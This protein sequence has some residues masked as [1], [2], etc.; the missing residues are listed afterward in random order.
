MTRPAVSSSLPSHRTEGSDKLPVGSSTLLSAGNK[1]NI[2][3]PV[4][5]K[6]TIFSHSATDVAAHVEKQLMVQSNI[7]KE[8]AQRLPHYGL[9]TTDE[10][11]GEELFIPPE[12]DVRVVGIADAPL[13]VTTMKR[14]FIHA[15]S[16]SLLSAPNFKDRKNETFK[17]LTEQGTTLARYDAEFLLKVALY[18]RCDLNIRTT[19][20][21]LL[22]LS[23][24][25]HSC[26]PHIRKYFGASI[27]LP[28]D[29]IEV[30]DI[31]QAFHDKSLNFGS[32]PS[33]LR[34]AMIERFPGFDVYQLAKYNK[35]SSKKKKKESPSA[36]WKGFKVGSP[37]RE[38]KRRRIL[39]RKD[40]S[41]SDAS[42]ESVVRDEESESEE[43]LQRLS[44][45]L[46]QLIRKLHM[47]KPVDH[48]M[49]ILGRKYPEDPEAFRRSGLPGMWDQDRAGKRMKLPTPEMWE[50]QVSLRGNKAEVW[51]D[52]IDHKKLPFMAMLRNLRNLILSNMS[53]KHHRLIINKLTDERS[54]VN[55]R[56][57]PFRFFSAYEVL[58]ELEKIAKDE[59]V[60]SSSRNTGK[61]GEQ[62]RKEAARRKLVEKIDVALIQRYKSALDTALKISTCYNVKPIPGSTLIFCSVGK[63]MK[64]RCTSARGLGK[65]RTV[66]EVGILLGLMCKFSCEHCRMWV[67]GES[68][69]VEVSLKEGTILDNMGVVLETVDSHS[70]DA[71]DGKL[72]KSVL[73][74]VLNSR[75][76]MDNL[77]VLNT[78]TDLGSIEGRFLSDFLK[79][80]RRVVNPNLL[81]VHVNLN[82]QSAGFSTSM[83][84]EH[85]NDIYLAGY[86]DQILRFIAERG[87][88]GQ[89]TYVQNIDK[90]YNLK[91]VKKIGL[92][93]IPGG[94]EIVPSLEKE[95]VFLA[96][97][98]TRIWRTVR[99]FISST[100]K[101]MHAERDLL[102]R[103]VFPEL[104]A[105]AHSRH[106]QLYEVD[107]RWGVTEE[108]ARSE[109]AVEICL[110]EVSRC[111]YFVGILGERYGWS[112]DKYQAPD[113]PEYEWLK[114]YP[115]GRSITE[116]EVYHAAL[117]QPEQAQNKAFFFF[118]DPSFL[119]EVPQEYLPSFASESHESHMKME[120]LKSRIRSSGLEV[121]DN[122]LARWL[123]VVEGKPMTGNLEDFGKRVLNVLWNRIQ[124]DFPEEDPESDPLVRADIA[125]SAF[126]Q[127][128]SE[129]FVGR[130]KLLTKAM[131]VVSHGPGG[132]VVGAGKPGSGKSAFMSAFLHHYSQLLSSTG[133]SDSNS[134]VVYHFIG[135][136]PDSSFL[137]NILFRICHKLKKH[138]SLSLSVPEDISE[139]LQ[140]WPVMLK[141][142]SEVLAEKAMLLILIDALDLLED[143]HGARTLEWIPSQ[144]PENVTIFVSCRE[145][146]S[147]YSALMHRR[148]APTVITIGALDVFDKAE[149]VRR[150]LGK[151]KKK[152]EETAFNNQMK[153]LLSKKEAVNP[154]YLH[155]ACEELRVFGIFE[156]VSSKIRQMSSTVAGLLQ[157]ILERLEEEHGLE[158]V[159][160]ALSLLVVARNG[161]QE[162]EL[163]TL[164]AIYGAVG[165]VQES[166]IQKLPPIMVARLFR[167]LLGYLQP[168][169]HENNDLLT[170]S[171]QDIEKAVRQR[172]MKG[173]NNDFERKLHTVASLYFK[174]KA[175]PKGDGSFKGKE[176]R[177]FSEL[178]YHLTMAGMWKELENLL[179]SLNFISAKAGFGLSH[180]LLEDYAPGV[181]SL[182]SM[183]AR[184]VKKVTQNPKVE[185]FHSFVSRNLHIISS[186][187]ALV[188]QQ[189]FNEPSQSSISQYAKSAVEGTS[190]PVVEWLNKPETEQ[191]CRLTIT[192]GLQNVMCVAVSS[193]EE[194]VSC[195]LSSGIAKVYE[196]ATGREVA[197]F[198][199]HAGPITGVTFVSDARLCTASKDS[200]LSL[201]DLKEG[202]RI[203]VMK[204]HTHPVTGCVANASGR[205]IVSVS[206]DGAVRVWNGNDGSQGGVL[207][208][209]N[210]SSRPVNC[211]SF[212][213]EG[214]LVA[215]GGWD[216]HVKIWDT[217]N[218]KRVKVLRGH[219][220]SVQSCAYSPS[221]RYVLSAALDGE[222]K[223]WSVKSGATL[224]TISGHCQPVSSLTFSKDGR[225]LVTASKDRTVKVWSGTLGT[226]I[227]SFGGEEE[228][229]ASCIAVLQDTTRESILVGYH[230]GVVRQYEFKS[231]KVLFEEKRHEGRVTAI[232]NHKGLKSSTLILSVSVDKT[233]KIWDSL[234]P[235]NRSVEFSGHSEAIL[236]AVWNDRL[237]AT[238]SEDLTIMVWPCVKEK[239]LK[240]Y[241]NNKK[242][243][244]PFP[245]EP[246][247]TLRGHKGPV[248]SLCYDKSNHCLISGSQD[249]SVMLW[250]AVNFESMR[251][252]R[253][254]H[255]DWI[256]ATALSD[257]SSDYLLTGSR[258]FTLKLWDMKSDSEKVT[259]AGHSSAVTCV[260]ISHG[261]VV[262][263]DVEGTVKVWTHKGAEITTLFAHK[264]RVNACALKL[265]QEITA[266]GQLWA[267]KMES[268]DEETSAAKK[269]Q[270]KHVCLVTAGDDGRVT[271]W[272]PFV[273]NSIGTL[274]GHTQEVLGVSSI[275]SSSIVSGSVD[276]TVKVW[277]LPESG[278]RCSDAH[279]GL[280]S[281]IDVN[282]ECSL[283]ASVSRD[284]TAILWNLRSEDNTTPVFEL[285]YRWFPSKD[286]EPVTEVKFLGRSRLVTCTCTSEVSIWQI[287]DT[288][289]PTCSVHKTILDVSK[290]VFTGD[291]LFAC[292]LKGTI[293]T[294]LNTNTLATSKVC[295]PH[296]DWITAATLVD[297]NCVVT[298]GLDRKLANVDSR[299]QKMVTGRLFEKERSTVS[300]EDVWPLSVCHVKDNRVAVGDSSGFLSV[301]DAQ[302]CLFVSEKQLHGAAINCLCVLDDSTIVSGADDSTVKIWTISDVPGYE[303][304]DLLSWKQVAQFYSTSPVT[305][306]CTLP[307]MEG[308]FL[309]GNKLGQV[310]ILR[311]SH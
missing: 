284:G 262:S 93:P 19:G 228:T 70:L 1:S 275:S 267:E 176:P 143:V 259:F 112:M 204:G 7:A 219:Q 242:S 133:R 17:A 134:L 243:K 94:E 51:Q 220:T 90:A 73:N 21:F 167:S 248:T 28:S 120:N 251:V 309:A 78:M 13:D 160:T 207:K 217:F 132:L 299:T 158:L 272:K 210:M 3:D 211:V 178:P 45:T 55:S 38:V 264:T 175:D 144:I 84:P 214:Q 139:L 279:S 310:H 61:T 115:S 101:D 50:T 200:T 123:G 254:C 177:A 246:V 271:V 164:L 179:T 184:E 300:K 127:S 239:D 97:G 253:E 212:D 151:H 205:V 49:C 173:G 75:I 91:A 156:E 12:R 150:R 16:A 183:M 10:T 126:A 213:P 180:R 110:G 297:S 2:S 124:K 5:A 221:G 230:N 298:V 166:G 278:E 113:T 280:V 252:L 25:L 163:S 145:G 140:C 274:V 68:R 304:K 108:D 256:T 40:S 276:K 286:E 169:S 30:A 85:P 103:Y 52:L 82:G 257:M 162:N 231:G 237:M 190:Y 305:S 57:F 104:R 185:A 247:S 62:Q 206:F 147:A 59:P 100:F 285:A 95:K 114:E 255:K 141:E 31:Y 26:R 27:R 47:V 36:K 105:R 76:H 277:S 37:D 22:A 56:Q 195:G 260:D 224:G 208:V 301:F 265:P 43:E 9:R 157:E 99:V 238:G 269:Q 67:Y 4:V 146:Q 98:P 283:A 295:S 186:S 281:A 153:L 128:E 18:T 24:N 241:L 223:I 20:N 165:V 32:L 261:C 89:L 187:P 201:W 138:F 64:R 233:G 46:K 199:G 14:N 270:L 174:S 287:S 236:C 291:K 227:A 161:L 102:T 311:F 250:D 69:P 135:A 87:D 307:N 72:P 188:F 106:I 240:D 216:T 308:A 245:F 302:K 107:L 209:Q 81:F 80:Y 244:I 235:S 289:I 181:Q 222:I 268:G 159:T 109:K 39:D 44:F 154:L 189:A 42:M 35:D 137:E 125:H 118:R 232:C 258:D 96:S 111:Q 218:K 194:L 229:P 48:I 29:W 273:A 121:Y 168:T 129:K 292:T 225:R 296:S 60:N 191:P 79:K 92:Q 136:S 282:K 15:I 83:Q 196:I 149:M 294:S 198:T 148:P 11:E 65:P 88:E 41:G 86:S 66:Q 8:A 77:V 203:Q 172:Y 130:N 226:P 122:F 266:S 117:A 155:L 116:V 6:S 131:D 306:L 33:A 303:L 182:P 202:H 152:L 171:H 234:S 54:V 58:A 170:F 192:G 142:V 71:A 290:L 215:V 193:N 74:D 293:I 197:T 249:N 288:S 63:E 263:G 34:K 53:Q 119:R 23:A